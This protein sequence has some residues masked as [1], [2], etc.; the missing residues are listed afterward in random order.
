MK[1]KI[2]LTACLICS[3]LFFYCGDNAV[4]P[5][6]EKNAD[7]VIVDSIPPPIV[8]ST[9]TPPI[10]DSTPTPEY[11]GKWVG[12]VPKITGYI[13]DQIKITVI[14]NKD[15]TFK[16]NAIYA[17]A[18]DTALRDNGSWTVSSDSIYLSGNDCA[19]ND[20]TT[21]ILRTLESCGNPAAIKIVIVNGTWDVP[22]SA[23]SPLGVAFGINLENATMKAILSQLKVR[24]FKN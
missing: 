4:D 7:P 3:T 10:V 5:P 11:V 6:K 15:S 21:H 12:A 16:L 23:L 9:P 19:V 13:N 2:V 14:I 18:L 8:D 22:L 24:L 17:T 1:E 20:T